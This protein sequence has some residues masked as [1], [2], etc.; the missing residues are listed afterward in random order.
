MNNI[1]EW[2]YPII[3]HPL[4]IIIAILAIL[5]AFVYVSDKVNLSKTEANLGEQLWKALPLV[6]IAVTILLD[7][8]EYNNLS[9]YLN[10]IG[11]SSVGI[12]VQTIMAIAL[13]I[14]MVAGYW[15]SIS[16]RDGKLDKSEKRVIGAIIF[17]NIVIIMLILWFGYLAHIRP[18]LH[19]DKAISDVSYIRFSILVV[20]LIF[21]LILSY[22]A[23]MLAAWKQ[24]LLLVTNRGN[25]STIG[26]T[27]TSTLQPT[28]NPVSNNP[29]PNP[30]PISIVMSSGGT[31]GYVNY[32]F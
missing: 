12:M 26:S 1:T 30:Q 16:M 18:Y 29:L 3:H 14:N 23:I 19:E 9:P 5:V 11:M 31:I 28:A 15:V 27:G 13:L 20:L 24:D 8:F 21:N 17:I 10:Y 32:P 25:S 22:I 4:T 2:I 7:Y 6:L